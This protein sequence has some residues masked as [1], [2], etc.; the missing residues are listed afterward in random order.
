MLK[1][2]QLVSFIAMVAICLSF[3]APV[4]VA[5]SAAVASSTYTSLSTPS[6]TNNVNQVLGKVQIDI[7]N[8]AAF[9]SPDVVTV[10]LP[11]GV[12][13]NV[14]TPGAAVDATSIS[15]TAP[16]T[17]TSGA[18]NP[19]RGTGAF[20]TRQTGSNS[21]D[22][23]V[24]P[25]A[26][27][28]GSQ[29]AL[30]V[31]DFFQM[32]V[33]GQSGD[34]T[35]TFFAPSGS[36]F[37]TGAANIGKV[38][39]SGGTQAMALSVKNISKANA[40]SI[41]T[42]LVA[43]TVPGTIVSGSTI[44]YTLPSGFTWNLPTSCYAVGGWSFA[45]RSATVAAPGAFTFEGNGTKKLT[46]TTHFDANTANSAG[47]VALGQDLGVGTATFAAINVPDTAAN[48]DV[49]CEIDGS[50]DI[51]DASIV[52]AKVGDYGTTV[53]EGEKT[54]VIAGM[55]EQKLGYF[56]IEESLAASLI[57]GRQVKLT[58]PA[59][60]K[61]ETSYY[62]TV[63][64]VNAG[65]PG[66]LLSKAGWSASGTD[67]RSITQNILAGGSTKAQKLKLKDM[68][69]Q[70]SPSFSGPVAITLSGTAGL[71]GEVAV[72]DAKKCV[73][74]TAASVKNITLGLPSQPI[75]D[76][77]LTETKKGNLLDKTE[78]DGVFVIGLDPGYI[79][80]VKPEVTVA[81]GN[82]E[83]DSY[84]LIND[85]TQ[86]Q[87]TVKSYSSTASKI[88]ISGAKLT[89]LRYVPEG[90]VKATLEAGT[91]ESDTTALDETTLWTTRESAGDLVVANCVTPAPVEQGRT[92]IF[93]IG[94]NVMTVNGSNVIMDCVP[95]I[96]A[97]RTFV[98]VS[99]L[100]T[101]LGATAAWDATAQTVTIT[102]GDKTIILTIGSKT[103]KV[104][105]ADVAMDVAPEIT[106]SRTMLPAR[107]VAEALGFTVG[108][109][110]ALKQ[111]I[112]Q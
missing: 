44:N 100:A 53:T 24:N 85:G 40:Q 92:V 36:G 12:T 26:F 1:H 8:I 51:S 34:I 11:S 52:I 25:S 54:E 50:G 65:A 103:A 28:T 91:T 32:D 97:G 83:I 74:F 67:G 75:D 112:I 108:W 77:F 98:P 93:Y 20:V 106:D 101:G 111:V 56:Y 64:M 94:S 49:V 73:E 76:L 7:P 45:G 10:S 105:G 9:T 96:K 78:N 42:I 30:L 70:V 29:S 109:N 69:I 15:V 88:K 110:A 21:F 60:C 3:L 86:L 46:I 39:T 55:K 84:K 66:T 18:G 2:K 33:V 17:T 37:T 71:T 16:A 5:P 102:K 62:P 19:L 57:S 41:D 63:E 80:A 82:L 23:W 59:G 13:Q 47:R 87:I 107:Y 79:W 89:A 6:V 48:G 99:Y 4:F 31:L 104:N 58:L 43:E 72:A 22:I 61:W 95:Y 90:P 35:A 81:E 27:A 38:V 68:K 14:Y